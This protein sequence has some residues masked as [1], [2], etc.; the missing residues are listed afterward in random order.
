[1]LLFIILCCAFAGGVV[2]GLLVALYLTSRDW[3]SH[4]DDPF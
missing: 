4:E 1:M 3:Y 2:A